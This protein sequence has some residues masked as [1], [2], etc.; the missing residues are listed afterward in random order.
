MNDAILTEYLRVGAYGTLLQEAF[1]TDADDYMTDEETALVEEFIEALVDET[2]ALFDEG[3]ALALAMFRESF[4]RF[5]ALVE[6]AE[7]AA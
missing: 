2:E 1:E 7:V 6:A 5:R 3:K 4:D